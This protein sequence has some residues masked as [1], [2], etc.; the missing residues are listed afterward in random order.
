MQG[1]FVNVV[2]WES[3]RDGGFDSVCAFVEAF[4]NDITAVIK[5][6]IGEGN[7]VFIRY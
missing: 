3:I 7:K 6:F 4:S 2:V 5:G 1:Q